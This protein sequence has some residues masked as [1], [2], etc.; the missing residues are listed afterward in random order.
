[1]EPSIAILKT[2][3][4]DLLTMDPYYKN[5]NTKE[6]ETRVR[7]VIKNMKKEGEKDE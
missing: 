2:Y 5:K 6:E 7:R 3:L 4:K 1:M